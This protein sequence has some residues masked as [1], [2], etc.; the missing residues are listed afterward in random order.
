MLSSL[1]RVEFSVYDEL[2][3][4]PWPRNGVIV[5]YTIRGVVLF[6]KV[7]IPKENKLLIQ[8]LQFDGLVS[9]R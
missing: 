3:R 6:L 4:V 2:G 5:D 8:K 7:T 9:G 1:A